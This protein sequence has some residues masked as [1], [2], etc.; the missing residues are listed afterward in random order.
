MT[1]E[2]KRLVE[3][4]SY[5]AGYCKARWSDDERGLLL[6]GAQEPWNPLVDDGDALRLA[7]RLNI[8]VLQRASGECWAQGPMVRTEIEPHGSDA[9]AATRR[10]IVRT[11]ASLADRKPPNVAL[12]RAARR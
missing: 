1:D 6:V 11:A 9:A 3:T 12:S 10:A 8:D 4:A 5:A 2:D 7:V